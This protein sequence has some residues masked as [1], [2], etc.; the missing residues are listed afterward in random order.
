MNR[1]MLRR[2]SLLGALLAVLFLA[3]AGHQAAAEDRQPAG[4]VAAQALDEAPAVAA[5]PEQTTERDAAAAQAEPGQDTEDVWSPDT[6][7]TQMACGD[8][9]CSG[10]LQCCWYQRC[11]A[12]RCVAW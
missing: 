1:S 9:R 7:P 12:G 11:S 6:S 5:A 8:R 10:S 3:F 2:I 4:P